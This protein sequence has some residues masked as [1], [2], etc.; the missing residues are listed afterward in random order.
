M[1]VVFTV[2]YVIAFLVCLLFQ[3]TAHAALTVSYA[4][5]TVGNFD[6]YEVKMLNDGIGGTGLQLAAF[7]VSVTPHLFS[8][9]NA[10]KIDFRDLD[11]DGAAD[12]NVMGKALPFG[13]SS[14]TFFRIGGS[15]LKDFVLLDL[16]PRAYTTDIEG[17]GVPNQVIDPDYYDLHSLH[18]AGIYIRSAPANITPV[19]FGNVVVPTGVSF[20]ITGIVASEASA[21][22]PF[23]AEFP[24]PNAL[25]FVLIGVSCL[26]RGNR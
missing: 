26:C 6:V 2:F 4:K 19:S 25:L 14:G 8:G 5:S 13:S 12:A 17:T 20:S 9:P 15:D 16:S 23:S 10:F 3:G 1:Q 21:S 18:M 11:D 22:I 24:E 7:D